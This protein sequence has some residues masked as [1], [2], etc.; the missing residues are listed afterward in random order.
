MTRRTIERTNAASVSTLAGLEKST[1]D[2][3]IVAMDGHPVE[4]GGVENTKRSL[5]AAKKARTHVSR[6]I[7]FFFLVGRMFVPHASDDLRITSR[8]EDAIS[9]GLPAAEV[10]RESVAAWLEARGAV[11]R[12]D[13]RIMATLAAHPFGMFTLQSARYAAARLRRRGVRRSENG[14]ALAEDLLGPEGTPSLLEALAYALSP[15]GVPDIDDDELDRVCTDVW[16]NSLPPQLDRALTAPPRTALWAQL[17]RNALAQAAATK[18]DPAGETMRIVLFTH[19]DA[20]PQRRVFHLL[21]EWGVM[22]Q[23]ARNCVSR[24]LHRRRYMY[25][26]IFR[27]DVRDL[28]LGGEGESMLSMLLGNIKSGTPYYPQLEDRSTCALRRT[29]SIK[30]SL[31]EHVARLVFGPEE[32]ERLRNKMATHID[33]HYPRVVDLSWLLYHSRVA[34][35]CHEDGGETLRPFHTTPF[36]STL[37][38][39]WRRMTTE[40]HSF[41]ENPVLHTTVADD[42]LA[43]LLRLVVADDP[44]PFPQAA[45]FYGAPEW[46]SRGALDHVPAPL[47]FTS[48]LVPP[49]IPSVAELRRLLV[50]R[51]AT[52]ATGDPQLFTTAHVQRIARYVYAVLRRR[53]EAAEAEIGPCWLGGERLAELRAIMPEDAAPA[54]A[55]FERE[56]RKKA[57]ACAV[58]RA[59]AIIRAR[60]PPPPIFAEAEAWLAAAAPSSPSRQY[61]WECTFTGDA[62][63][64][65]FDAEKQVAHGT[66]VPRAVWEA[67]AQY[68]RRHPHSW[69]SDMARCTLM[70]CV[71]KHVLATLPAWEALLLRPP[72]GGVLET[73]VASGRVTAWMLRWPGACSMHP[74]EMRARV[75]CRCTSQTLPATDVFELLQRTLLARPALA[76]LLPFDPAPLLRKCPPVHPAQ[77]R[78]FRF[79]LP[80]ADDAACADPLLLFRTHRRRTHPGAYTPAMFSPQH[81]AE[82]GG[83]A[84]RCVARDARVLCGDPE[85]HCVHT[86]TVARLLPWFASPSSQGADEVLL[87]FFSRR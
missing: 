81:A 12:N 18:E 2:M 67:F 8:M 52:G 31:V 40:L 29:S 30:P 11:T 39:L 42:R 3:S 70:T 41:V 64:S 9:A 77:Q 62:F 20:D 17:P 16:L 85:C 82:V 71:G 61:Y 66:G 47:L 76:Q 56:L 58:R 79:T 34:P 27:P 83:V 60:H 5:R 28:L 84:R 78:L 22:P 33:A 46:A 13:G 15:M 6:P 43:D 32:C 26:T 59:V 44:R 80:D 53:T 24:V 21:N 69:R 19:N 51:K 10:S 72:A 73:V 23:T 48:P 36:G 37:F 63:V 45:Q 1:M 35:T 57:E 50:W 4:A 74:R 75:L 25:A 87:T 86:G 65:A 38:T 54:I 49:G 68:V 7:I 14:A 55:D